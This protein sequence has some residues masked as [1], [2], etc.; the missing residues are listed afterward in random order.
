MKKEQRDGLFVN[1]AIILADEKKQAF[2]IV[3]RMI[4]FFAIMIGCW[5]SLGILLDCIQLPINLLT[6]SVTVLICI[7]IIFSLCMI[8]KYELVKLFSG[9]L[10]YALIFLVRFPAIRNGFYILENSVI[11]RLKTYYGFD[12][13]TY[14]ANYATAK[15]DTT[16]LV[17]MMVIPVV[18]L[19]TVGIVRNRCLTV[20]GILLFLPIAISFLF[21]LILFEPYMIA[22]VVAMLYLTRAGF[23][24]EHRMKQEHK[25]M[26][27]RINSKAAVWLSVLALLI[28]LIIK[29]FISEDKYNSITEI[30][31][32]KLELQTA[33][34]IFQWKTSQKLSRI[35]IC[36]LRMEQQAV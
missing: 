33:L 24:T 1:K 35:L 8:Q 19:F 15:S 36:L 6:I 12:L 16:I 11:D 17:V 22:S 3:N 29:L 27:H 26:L 5:G 20:A 18:V 4:Q 2:P 32:T 9:I 30:K 7:A 14:L 10:I 34:L 28:F 21:G 31:D 23:P 25:I 13:G